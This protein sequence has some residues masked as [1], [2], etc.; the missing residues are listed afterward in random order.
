MYREHNHR[1]AGCVVSKL[2][3]KKLKPAK[4]ALRRANC[5]V[6]AIKR[7]KGKS[8]QVLNQRPKPGKVLAPGAKVNLTVGR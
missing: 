6:G 3:G 5:K 8:G 7:R 2:K 1:E 4:K